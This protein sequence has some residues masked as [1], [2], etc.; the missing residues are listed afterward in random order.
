MFQHNTASKMK[1]CYDIITITDVD[2]VWTG[3]ASPLRS[4]TG[5]GIICLAHSRFLSGIAMSG[6]VLRK[7]H[8]LHFTTA[9]STH[10]K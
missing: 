8:E 1:I 6:S 5:G 9:L 7:N 2:Q 3:R 4:A 10:Q